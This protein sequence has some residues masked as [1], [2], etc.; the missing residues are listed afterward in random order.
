MGFTE[1]VNN[2]LNR[3][4]VRHGVMA[5]LASTEWGLEAGV[6]RSTHIALVTSLIQYGLTTL[7]GHIYEEQ[8]DRLDAQIVNIAAR[9]ITGVHR[10]ARLEVLRLTAG[11]TSVRNMIIQQ[12]GF[13]IIRALEA[14]DSPL[15]EWVEDHIRQAYGHIRWLVKQ[16]ML[17]PPAS[18]C[19]RTNRHG[20]QEIEY[21]DTWSVRLL[22][23]KAE[24]GAPAKYRVNSIFHTRADVIKENPAAKEFFYNFQNTEN[25]F[26]VGMQVLGA[27]RWRPDCMHISRENLAR[28]L[29]PPVSPQHP[30]TVGSPTMCKWLTEEQENEIADRLVE[31]TNKV[32]IQVTYGKCRN[33]FY[34]SSCCVS[35]LYG[36]ET[37]TNFIGVHEESFTPIFVR[38]QV[39]AV[40]LQYVRKYMERDRAEIAQT[41]AMEVFLVDSKICNRLRDWHHKGAWRFET[42]AGEEIADLSHMF[43]VNLH[44]PAGIYTVA[45]VGRLGKPV[46]EDPFDS[47]AIL[48][49][50]NERVKR[51]M[52]TNALDSLR[53]RWTRV[54]LSKDGVCNLIKLKHEEDEPKAIKML[55]QGYSASGG[56][57]Q[58]IG[59]ARPII[60][61]T[62][63]ELAY[64]RKYQT[65][66][67]GII[68]ATRYKYSTEGRLFPTVFGRCGQR[69][70][71]FS[72]D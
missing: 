46:I 57:F 63:A 39:L 1:H 23:E 3:A 9:R 38:E 61:Q 33:H 21:K 42:G 54:P 68:C 43:A 49:Y 72:Y 31:A 70:F 18:P 24:E 53:G 14:L 7:G 65:A 32:E 41:Q 30:M 27:V 51:L 19:G 67:C 26:D 5:Q 40:A 59:L 2:I 17:A 12:C 4:L 16:E 56:I 45:K 66:L 15:Q 37:Q 20:F 52:S 34:V 55:E 50:T 10:S 47:A 35:T 11:L 60:R 6:L 13:M 44:F 69:N 8:P 71:F 36:T 62:L 28:T 22:A 29:P 64:T 25:W 58:K 48:H